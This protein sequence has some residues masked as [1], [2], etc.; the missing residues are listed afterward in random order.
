MTRLHRFAFLLSLSLAFPG[1]AEP[2]EL[3]GR[4]GLDHLAEV[5]G[6]AS[7]GPEASRH[8]IFAWSQPPVEGSRYTLSGRVAYEGVEGRGYLEMWSHFGPEGSFFSRTLADGGPL[9]S[10]SGDSS[11]RFFSLP[12]D[13]GDSGLLP[14]RVEVNIVLPGPG[15]VRVSGLRWSGGPTASAAPAWRTRAEVGRLGAVIGV[16]LGFLGALAGVL[17]GRGRAR[18]VV[19]SAL[20][21]S[22]AIGLGALVLGVFGFAAEQPPYLFAPSLALGIAALVIGGFGVLSA[23]RRYA[24]LEFRKMRAVDLQV[25]SATQG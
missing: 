16:A 10:L 24:D 15:S 18:V 8:L 3:A 14:E 19:M 7:G 1:N 21:L 25:G 12:F 4:E 11:G 13:T 2:T 6:S 17:G 23:R 9:A 5:M 22:M 20:A